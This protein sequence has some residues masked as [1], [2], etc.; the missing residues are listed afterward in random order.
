[1]KFNK[2]KTVY[3]VLKIVI[4]AC[5]IGFF[6]IFSVRIIQKKFIYPLS[7][8]DQII[9]FSDKYNLDYAFVFAVVKCESSFNKHAVSNKGAIGLMQITAS[10]GE[11]MAKL[12]NKQNYNLLNYKDNLEIGCAYLRY[13]YDKFK[14]LDT[15][16]A[17][18]NA[19]EGNVN[20][21]LKNK[22]Y[23]KDGITLDKIPY[24]ETEEYLIKIKK[25]LLKYQN[26]YGKLL[27]KQQKN[28]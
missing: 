1:M 27:D 13:L 24:K 7:Y 26:L 2:H 28:R 20:N 4:I 3:N 8:C 16:I 21:W 22:E 5:L 18:Y 15:V 19:G 25:T 14:V 6:A 12:I 17:S 9:E 10:T 11:Y 23:S